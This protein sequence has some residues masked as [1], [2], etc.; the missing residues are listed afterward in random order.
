[1]T[2]IRGWEG[3]YFDPA[4]DKGPGYTVEGYKIVHL[5]H[6]GSAEKRSKIADR[7]CFHAVRVALESVANENSK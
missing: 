1:M 3:E 7:M 5:S 4:V 2:L 6:V